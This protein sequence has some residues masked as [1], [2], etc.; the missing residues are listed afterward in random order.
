LPLSKISPPLF[1]R[2]IIEGESKRG[3]ASLSNGALEKD[4]AS[5]SS[6]A[7][8]KDEV[9][10]TNPSPSPSQGEGDKGGEVE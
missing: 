4:E 9:P 8:E 6:G 10:L 1:R 2:R 5:L 7:L 3:E